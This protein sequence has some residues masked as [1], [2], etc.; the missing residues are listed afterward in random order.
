MGKIGKLKDFNFYRENYWKLIFV[1]DF[2]VTSNEIN[3]SN[4][5]ILC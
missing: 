1:N 4:N 5:N 3:L 2:P